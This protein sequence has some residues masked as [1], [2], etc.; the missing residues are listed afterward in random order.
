MKNNDNYSKK[1]LR[2]INIKLIKIEE[3]EY[4]YPLHIKAFFNIL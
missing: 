2:V 1:Y 3:E 4:V